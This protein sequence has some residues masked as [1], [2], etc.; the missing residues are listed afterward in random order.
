M[1][2]DGMGVMVS[3][4]VREEVRNSHA[5]PWCRHIDDRFLFGGAVVGRSF[6]DLTTT[7]ALSAVVIV[8]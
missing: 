5:G 6:Y 7:C 4:V 1:L 3:A 2:Q 8:C